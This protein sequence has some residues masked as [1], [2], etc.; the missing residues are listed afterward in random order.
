MIQEKESIAL[1]S[2]IS[3]FIRGDGFILAYSKDGENLFGYELLGNDEKAP[4]ILH[5]LGA[6]SGKFRIVGNQIPFTMWYQFD[7]NAPVPEHLGFVFD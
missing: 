5:S 6:K 7:K 2:Q 3:E 1:L 4:E